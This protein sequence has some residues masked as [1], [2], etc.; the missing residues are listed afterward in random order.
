M[1]HMVGALPMCACVRAG[2]ESILH[3]WNQVVVLTKDKTTI[4]VRL[5][6]AKLS[7]IGEDTMFVALFEVGAG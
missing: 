3:R 6:I 7:G 1:V 2:R 5:H 4:S